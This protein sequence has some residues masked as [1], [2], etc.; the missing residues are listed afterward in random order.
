MDSITQLI[1]RFL[2][3]VTILIIGVEGVMSLLDRLGFLPTFL[4]RFYLS[5]DKRTVSLTI[6]ELVV[7]RDFIVLRDF[8]W[9]YETLRLRRFELGLSERERV[10]LR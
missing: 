2:L 1:G 9:Y 7:Q 8:G 6:Q 10:C 4:E 5:R 3:D